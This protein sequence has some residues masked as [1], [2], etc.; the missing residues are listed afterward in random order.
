MRRQQL[1]E[2]I[3]FPLQYKDVKMGRLLPTFNDGEFQDITFCVTEQCNF[4]CGYCYMS[5]KNDKN[6]TIKDK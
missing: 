3:I 4:R 5:G 1:K 2:K 6:V